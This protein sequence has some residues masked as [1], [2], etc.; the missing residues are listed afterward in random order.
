MA[1]TATGGEKDTTKW[2]VIPAVVLISRLGATTQTNDL[3]VLGMQIEVLTDPDVPSLTVVGAKSVVNRVYRSIG[4]EIEWTE[5]EASVSGV[6]P[7]RRGVWRR[8]AIK[9]SAGHQFPLA[10]GHIDV[11]GVTPRGHGEP[12]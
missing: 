7:A 2:I 5:R 3:P 10:F 4:V 8:V 9:S 11:L 12:G 1:T 6:D